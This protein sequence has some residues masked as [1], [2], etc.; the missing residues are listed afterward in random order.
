MCPFLFT[1]FIYFLQNESELVLEAGCKTKKWVYKDGNAVRYEFIANGYLLENRVCIDKNYRKY[2]APHGQNTKVHT[3][4]EYQ[5]I[6]DVDAK[7][8]TISIDLLLTLK[9]FDPGIITNFDESMK[10]A[11]G[12]SLRSEKIDMIWIPDL[13]I[14]NRTSVKAKDEWALLKTS[15]ILDSDEINIEEGQFDT[16]IVELKYEIKTSI[17]CDFEYSKYPMD[18]QNCFLK[19]GSGSDD[20]LF[21]LHQGNKSYHDT[22]YYNAV[23]LN[24][25]ISFFGKENHL[26]GN[27]VGFHIHM[28]RTMT[29]FIMKY[30][31]PTTAIVFVSEVGFMVPLTAIP[32]RV[33]LLV[34]Q[35]L[36]LI[37]LFIFQM[38]KFLL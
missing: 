29:P 20:A 35:F 23:G 36:T 24:L 14:W 3:T 15:K 33:A 32:G 10:R 7:K 9:W 25:K 18:T 16:T 8:Q 1:D 37:N 11:G 6:R 19:I 2:I 26:R 22:K 12:I 28:N 38:V 31:I 34:T 13:Y 21:G 30:Y 5:R 4:I 17:Y 27:T